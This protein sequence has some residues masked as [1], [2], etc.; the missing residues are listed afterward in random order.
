M[1]AVGLA[2]QGADTDLGSGL[3]GNKPLPG[4]MMTQIP[5]HHMK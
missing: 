5:W 4:P 3:D 2:M 1:A